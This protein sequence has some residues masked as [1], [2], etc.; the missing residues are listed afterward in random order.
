[1]DIGGVNGKCVGPF[2]FNSCFSIEG[3]LRIESFA[4][5]HFKKLSVIEGN[6]APVVD[7]PQ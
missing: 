1:M 4:G 5:W 2:Q 7:R 3:A 6:E